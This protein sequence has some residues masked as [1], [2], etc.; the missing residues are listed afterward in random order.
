MSF[1]VIF[2]FM[3]MQKM[4]ED[5]RREIKDREYTLSARETVKENESKLENRHITLFDGLGAASLEVVESMEGIETAN[6]ID[7]IQLETNTN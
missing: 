3:A 7:V 4:M 6:E 2:H 1:Y 5:K